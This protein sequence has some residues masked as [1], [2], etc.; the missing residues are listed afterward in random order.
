MY[1]NKVLAVEN[2]FDYEET[3]K[4][5][6]SYFLDLERLQWEWAKFNLQKGL[7]VN[8]DFAVEYKKQPYMPITEDV[9]ALCAKESKEEQLKIHLSSYYWAKSILTDQ[10]QL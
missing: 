3:K 10:E 4:K 9:F 8:Y 7:T 2:C 5:V 6:S 1:S